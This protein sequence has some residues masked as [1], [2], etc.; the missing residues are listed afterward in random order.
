MFGL[1]LQDYIEKNITFTNDGSRPNQDIYYNI[2]DN[3]FWTHVYCGNE[4]LSPGTEKENILIYKIR[5]TDE[6]EILCENCDGVENKRE[7]DCELWQECQAQ[8]LYEDIK[9]HQYDDL[10]GGNGI[11][12]QIEDLLEDCHYWEMA[13][14]D[15]L[16]EERYGEYHEYL[17]K[18]YNNSI[19][20]DLCD[21]LVDDIVDYGFFEKPNDG[22]LDGHCETLRLKYGWYDKPIKDE[23]L[24]ETL[25]LLGENQIVEALKVLKA[26]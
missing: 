26:S 7:C 19:A 18:V 11:Y 12:R 9:E 4:S 14:I 1:D 10:W 6:F 24:K 16:L 15:L 2:K 5:N 17:N 8:S 21:Q 23:R 3:E 25:E 13:E 20:T 22:W